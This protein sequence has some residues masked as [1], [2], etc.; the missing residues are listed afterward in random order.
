M[1]LIVLQKLDKGDTLVKTDGI[2]SHTLSLV[3][4]HYVTQKKTLRP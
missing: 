3:L 1:L 4:N 2:Y